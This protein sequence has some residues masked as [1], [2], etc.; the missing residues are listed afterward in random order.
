MFDFFQRIF[1]ILNNYTYIIVVFAVF[2]C[3]FAAAILLRIFVCVGYQTQYAMFRMNSKP[4]SAKAD[5]DKIKIGI[6]R[7]VILDY[8][9][10]A[11]KNSSGVHL[12]AIVKKHILRLSFMGWSYD[13]IE[14]LLSVLELSLPM[15]GVVLA[16]IFSDEKAAYG[17]SAVAMLVVFRIFASLFDFTLSK[18]KLSSEMIEYVEREVGQF[19]AG[20]F[21]SV[22]IRFKNETSSALKRQAE[23]LKEVI[24]KLEENLSGAMR[25]TMKEISGE[26]AL[27]GA[28]LDEPLR[29]WSQAIEETASL[30][31][32]S[33]EA[34]SDMNELA[35][36]LRASGESLEYS[37]RSH[38]E[39]LGGQFSAFLGHMDKMSDSGR[40]LADT[41][42]GFK[43]A[44]VQLEKQIGY[45]DANQ[46]VL[47]K[48][49][50]QYELSLTEM[51]AKMGDGFGSILD[52]HATNSYSALN[53]GLQSTV[54][55][56][57]SSNKEV[58]ERMQELF[59]QLA[60]SIRSEAGAIMNM[61]EQIGLHFDS[62]ESR[63]T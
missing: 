31:A 9:K 8:I 7:G 62:L 27:I 61:N 36:T 20:D 51:T 14:R 3:V 58:L 63:M 5:L 4:I 35:K 11:E 37:L 12:D 24:A 57:A 41:Y 34:L 42:E 32:K 52:Y 2:L 33:S 59:E 13:S 16:Y 18:S 56:I 48:A 26:M 60:L 39:K 54:R 15:A 21:G 40:R 28:A 19:Y 22:L 55:S 30:Q 50:T 53:E 49:L 29:K 6:L 17:I 46:G 45:I 10:T 38:S 23:T 25:L 43:E 47:E 44:C 1:D